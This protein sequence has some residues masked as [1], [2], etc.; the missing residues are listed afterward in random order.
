MPARAS[1]RAVAGLQR[2]GR[3]QGADK[4]FV[5]MVAIVLPFLGFGV[6]H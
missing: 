1:G 5:I 2:Q 6:K 3:I 4:T